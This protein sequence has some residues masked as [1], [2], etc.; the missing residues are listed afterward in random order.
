[1][2]EALAQ[3]PA[4]ARDGDAFAWTP[5]D[6]AMAQKLIYR[7]AGI[8]LH[9][10]KHAMV[11]SRLARRLRETGHRSF[12]DYLRTLHDGDGGELQEFINALTTNLTSFFREVHHF[13]MLR[14]HLAQAPEHGWRIWC[15]AASTGEEPYSIAITAAETLGLQSGFSVQATDIDS[16]VLQ[17]ARD[18]IYAADKVRDMPADRLRRFFER[19]R[20]GNAGRVRIAPTLGS[21]VEFLQLNLIAPRWPLSGPFDV[22]FC[23]NVM[24]YFDAPT[25]RAVL[26]RMHAMLRPGGLLF[27]GHAE[28]IGEARSLFRLRGKTAYE[29]CE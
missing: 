19:G 5:E 16:R 17:Q 23:R 29:R 10:G 8:R 9:D 12:R 25:Q 11:Y 13:D 22:I 21:Q 15:S 26:Q 27:L 18:G 1:M 24:I 14:A 20:G 6:F 2:P 7:H 3:R 28:N 4:A